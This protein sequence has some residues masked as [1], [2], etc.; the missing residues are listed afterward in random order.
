MNTKTPTP[1]SAS[2]YSYDISD[3]ASANTW[4]QLIGDGWVGGD[5]NRD[6]LY[7]DDIQV[8]YR[9]TDQVGGS[10]AY[11]S[12]EATGSFTVTPVN[13]APAG[14]DNTVSTV[15]NTDYVFAA[16][17]FGFADTNDNPA[18]NLQ[19]VK[20]TSLPATGTLTLT[21]S[22]AVV[23]DQFITK[24]DLDA[25]KLIFTP[26]PSTSG[27]G[28][29]GFDFQV[30]DD[31][32]I[33]NS[34]IDLDPAADTIT[35]DVATGAVDANDDSYG[36]DADTTLNVAAVGV[37]DNDILSGPYSVTGGATLEY[38][39][40][41]DV[42]ANNVWEDETGVAGYDLDF[43]GAT[44]VRDT[45]LSN[46]PSGIS[47]AYVFDGS[48]GGEFAEFFESLPG[49]PSDAAAS[50]EFWI[51]PSDASGREI[52]FDTGSGTN[53][54]GHDGASLRLNDSVLEWTVWNDG[55]GDVV[56]VTHDIAA[57]IASGEFI[58]VMAGFDTATGTA[59]LR[60][61]GGAA[62][63]DSNA[64][65]NDWASLSAATG[66]AQVGGSGTV[67]LAPPG[68]NPFAGEI[69]AL[70]FYEFALNDAQAQANY[71]ALQ[72]S[73]VSH[74]VTSAAGASV[75]VNA[76]GS[77]AY[78]PGSLFDA[79]G[80]GQTSIDTF[81]YTVEDGSGNFDTATVSVA[82]T[83]VNEDPTGNGSLGTTSLDDNAGAT[84]LFG[85]LSVSDVDSNEADLVLRITLSDATAGTHQRRRLRRSWAAA[86][87]PPPA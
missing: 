65:I 31:G 14:A 18:N 60:V 22:G 37:L 30:Q 45:S 76:D 82:V 23:T 7:F 74:D 3:Y 4:I 29:A 72:L 66:V 41:D 81:G 34:G 8:E 6:F 86:C 78:D 21:G 56:T 38:L 87:T 53:A 79:L 73:V 25:G 59:S 42:D 36:T 75:T 69:A 35:I 16:D 43:S 15:A 63:T 2:Q 1:T 52:L 27:T 17:D 67:V 77:F 5:E 19:A 44:V 32:G 54:M 10:T 11:S 28:Y 70:R 57:E 51:R 58:Q 84:T 85:D 71:D 48:G 20:I 24:A 33:L 55:L 39:A 47:A 26:V 46:A 9:L 68:A 40:W 80:A 83:G 12:A 64:A 49:D 62:S 50:F 61:N 13:D